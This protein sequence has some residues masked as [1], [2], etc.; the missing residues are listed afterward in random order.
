M[1]PFSFRRAQRSAVGLRVLVTGASGTIGQALGRRLTA[2]GAV[3][4]GLD[5][6]PRGD[7]GFEVLAC[8]ITDE[9]STAGAVE[10]ALELLGGLDVL[11]NNA[12]IGGPAPAALAPG[13]EVRRQL[14]INL[15]GAWR[16][17][18]ACV[19]ALVASRGRVVMVTSRMA[20]MQLPLAAAYG[21]SKR[22]LVAYADAL[23]LELGTHVSVT[24]VYPSAVRSPIHD[25]TQAAGLSLEG[26]STYESLE[27]VVDAITRSCLVVRARRDVTTTAK[28]AVEFWLSRHLPVVTDRIVLRTLASRTRAGAFGDAELAAGVVARHAPASEATR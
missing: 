15:L 4:V 16:V 24:C 1:S 11:V 26:M 5:L 12:G 13:A 20:V 3:V 22:A 25:S 27:G 14:E 28:G 8:D 23:R 10:R 7:E 2:A 18:A 19:D 21:A 17:T 6:A 9:E